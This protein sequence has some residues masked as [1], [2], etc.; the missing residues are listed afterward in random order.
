M[1]EDRLDIIARAFLSHVLTDQDVRIELRKLKR[2]KGLDASRL[3]GIINKVLGEQLS[4]EE[5]TQIKTRLQSVARETTEALCMLFRVEIQ[6]IIE[7]H[8]GERPGGDGDDDDG[9][10]APDDDKEGDKPPRSP[11]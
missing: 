1:P 5:T 2:E 4:R 7:D 11:A 9:D 6:A 8:P 10:G 3:S